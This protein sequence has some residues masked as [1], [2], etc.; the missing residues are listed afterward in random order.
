MT[1]RAHVT[2]LCPVLELIGLLKWTTILFRRSVGPAM[3]PQTVGKPP[4]HHCRAS[5]EST[6]RLLRLPAPPDHED[7]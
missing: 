5:D 7:R 1:A 6:F 3:N 4:S 2:L